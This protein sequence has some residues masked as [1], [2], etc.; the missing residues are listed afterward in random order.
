MRQEGF[1]GYA[2]GIVAWPSLYFVAGSCSFL[3]WVV[4]SVNDFIDISEPDAGSGLRLV[5]RR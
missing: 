4:V 1:H 2:V 5:S 3:V